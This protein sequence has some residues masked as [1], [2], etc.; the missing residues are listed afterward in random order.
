MRGRVLGAWR[1]ASTSWGLAG[2]PVLGALLELLGA[3][4]GLI[5]GGLASILLL[6]G[7]AAVSMRRRRTGVDDA[8]VVPLP[9]AA[10]APARMAA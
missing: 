1:T 7:V 9:H 3:R 2:P 6:A 8:T 4:R 10:P 5:V